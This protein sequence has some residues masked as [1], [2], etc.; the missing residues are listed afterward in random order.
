MGKIKEIDLSICGSISDSLRAIRK[1]NCFPIASAKALQN[2]LAL[3]CSNNIPHEY[4]VSPIGYLEDV[5]LR[6]FENNEWHE[7]NWL[8]V[9]YD[10][11]L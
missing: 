6:W 4:S 2:M 9:V 7:M 11:E 8:G 3:L 10:Y 5:K 1:T